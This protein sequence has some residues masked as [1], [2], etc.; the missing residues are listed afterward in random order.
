MIKRASCPTD[1]GISI[2]LNRIGGYIDLGG[3]HAPLIGELNIFLNS[4]VGYIDL[5][6]LHAPLIGGLNIFFNSIVG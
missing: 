6:G 2:F 1:R 5:G 3:L 4:I